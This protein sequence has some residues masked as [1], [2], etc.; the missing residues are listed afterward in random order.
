MSDEEISSLPAPFYTRFSHLL[1]TFELK[2]TFRT[3]KLGPGLEESHTIH[4]SLLSFPLTLPQAKSPSASH[5]ER[6]NS[7]H[8]QLRLKSIHRTLLF[9]YV[10]SWLQTF[11]PYNLPALHQY[12]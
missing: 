10:F 4:L 5:L 7:C 9:L 2:A 3:Y 6:R 1:A 8:I 11:P 12:H